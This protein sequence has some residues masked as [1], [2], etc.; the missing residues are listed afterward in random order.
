M[1]VPCELNKSKEHDIRDVSDRRHLNLPSMPQNQT[2]VNDV[3]AV[4]EHLA[5]FTLLRKQSNMEAKD[6]L[7]R[8]FRFQV[9]R[10]DDSAAFHPG[11]DEY[12]CG[13]TAEG[14]SADST[15]D[16]CQACVFLGH[17]L[18]GSGFF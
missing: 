4:S 13:K 18:P 1:R 17:Y 12:P 15:L 6:H 11:C 5:R 3:C 9:L 2:D 7:R 14:Y 16:I 8:S 10:R